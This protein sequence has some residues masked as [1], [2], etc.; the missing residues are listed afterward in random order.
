MIKIK[1]TSKEFDDDVCTKVEGEV[2]GRRSV[3]VT[4]V[5]HLLLELDK[6]EKDILTDAM[7]LMLDK[8]IEE[9]KD[10]E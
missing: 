7:G 6:L 4:E 9:S 1:V 2:S 5:A 10:D 3:L 8:L